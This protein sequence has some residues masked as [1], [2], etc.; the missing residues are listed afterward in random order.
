MKRFLLFPVA[1]FAVAVF[2]EKSQAQIIFP[3]AQP[4]GHK[5]LKFSVQFRSGFPQQQQIFPQ[6]VNPLIP[7]PVI[8]PGP[9]FHNPFLQPVNPDFNPGILPGHGCG[10]QPLPISISYVIYYRSCSRSPWQIYG[11]SRSL[12]RARSIEQQLELRGYDVKVVAQH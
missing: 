7:Q 9:S 8:T 10:V 4:Q 2:T 6:P 3:G 12:H 5:A 11:E 1:V